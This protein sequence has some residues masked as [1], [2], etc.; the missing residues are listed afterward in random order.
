MKQRFLEEP[1]SSVAAVADARQ[2]GGFEYVGA[3]MPIDLFPKAYRKGLEI[4][5][6]HQV[7][8][9]TG[10]RIIGLGHCMM[11]FY[12]YAFNRADPSDVKLAQEALEDTNA[13]V[14]EMGGIPWKAEAPAQKQ[15]IEKMD[16]N[17][18]S[19]MNRIREV[20]DPK[21]NHEP[22]ELGDELMEYAEILHRCFRC[23]YCKLPGS[24]QDLN[25]PSYLKF[26]FESYAPGGRM[27][28]LRAW[29]DGEIETSPRL[30]EILF[31]CCACG[32]CVE[33]CVFDA[34]KADL[35]N[36]FTAGREE[37]IDRGLGTRRGGEVS[38]SH[39]LLRQSLQPA[40]SRSGELG[41]RSG[42]RAV[43]R[44][45]VPALCGVPRLLRRTG[46]E[47]GAGG[48]RTCS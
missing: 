34:F 21:R 23:G 16:P 3:I 45:G 44:A 20:L 24:Y 8:F 37:L 26:R 2:G 42:R 18:F 11:F 28:L 33:H 14:L 40:R 47:D 22:R 38:R 46:P 5:E 17:T 19:L 15:I 36:A 4:A 10:A 48:G 25:C 41:R 39:P 13:A 32:N 9:T 12:V 6:R 1:D 29:L 27:W 30:A 31:S 7:P 43:F 35:L